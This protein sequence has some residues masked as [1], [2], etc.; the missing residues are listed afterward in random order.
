V[1]GRPVAVSDV[2]VVGG[3]LVGASVAYELSVLGAGVT[4]VEASLRGRASDAGAGIVSPETIADPD[5]EFSQFCSAAAAHL[6][7][8]V[9][10][11]GEDGADIA[12]TAFARCGSLVV[13]LAEHEDPWFCEV[14]DLAKER[15][16]EVGEVSSAEAL[17][18]FPPLAGVWRALHNRSAARVDG[19]LLTAGLHAGA[20]HRG[21]TSVEAEVLGMR[22]DSGRVTGV[23][24][25]DGELACDMVVIAAGA[26]SARCARSLGVD[27]AVGPTKGQIVHVVSEEWREQSGDWPIVQPV[28]NFYL[29]PWPGGRVACGGTFEAGESFDARPTAR[30]MRDLLRELVN[31][32]PGL[33]P[34][35]FSEVR[36]GLRPVCVDD[37]PLLGPVGGWPNVHLCTGHGANGLMLGPYSGA[38]VARAITGAPASS[39]PYPAD[40]LDRANGR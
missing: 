17:A 40:R 6:A 12:P 8:L 21:A 23:S 32:A 3:G 4:V 18:M 5:P 20:R 30:G 31:I 7:S 37:R 19:R 28:L 26:W 11:L 13:A 35:T 36:V 15:S 25:T 10:R 9:E 24:T 22:V 1:P 38:I 2:V 16:S 39:M 27:V 33:G 34:A 14:A 29:V